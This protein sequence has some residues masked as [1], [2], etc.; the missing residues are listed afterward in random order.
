MGH[1]S[2]ISMFGDMA[3][4]SN[5]VTDVSNVMDCIS[6]SWSLIISLSGVQERSEAAICRVIT[7]GN[8]SV[9]LLVTECVDL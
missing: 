1:R 7:P 8:A 2:E 5:L 3:D 4:C 9:A 6:E